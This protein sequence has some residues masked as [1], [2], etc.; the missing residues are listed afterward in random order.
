MMGSADNHSVPIADSAFE[1]MQQKGLLI[2]PDPANPDHASLIKITEE[3]A[4]E[5]GYRDVTV[6]LKPVT[7]NSEQEKHL[8]RLQTGVYFAADSSARSIALP[9][10]ASYFFTEGEIKA[11]LSHE[12]THFNQ[13]AL[14]GELAQAQQRF[15]DARANRSAAGDWAEKQAEKQASW[16]ELSRISTAIEVDAD[17]GV[18]K[19]GR[20]S[21]MVSA[22][23]KIHMMDLTARQVE[24]PSGA[25]DWVDAAPAQLADKVTALER[26]SREME[27]NNNPNPH[28]AE[29]FV[30]RLARLEQ[31][32]DKQQGRGR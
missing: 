20:A 3:A 12:F 22:L 7:G 23:Q 13:P 1:R 26:F 28:S 15:A 29:T 30:E 2:R 25:Q 9:E 10:C 32:T 21:D 16:Q 31:A 6:Y 27:R 4:Q 8:S 19:A 18:V 5:A 14:H 24:A 17:E 11:V